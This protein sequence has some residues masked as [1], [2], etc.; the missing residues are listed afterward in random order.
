MTIKKILRTIGY[1]AFG[2]FVFIFLT[3][4][5][6]PYNKLKDSLF[7][8]IGRQSGVIIEAEDMKAT[9]GLAVKLSDVSLSHQRMNFPTLELESITLS[10]SLF[11]LVT[12]SPKI[13]FD[14]ALKKGGLNGYFQ[15]GGRQRVGLNLKKIQLQNEALKD[16]LNLDIS[17][18]LDGKI[19]VSGNLHDTQTLSGDARLDIKQFVLAKTKIMNMGLPEITISEITL[20][21]DL[22]QGTLLIKKFNAG[23]PAEDLEAQA[24]GDIRLDSRNVM[25]S[26]IT[27]NLKFKLSKKLQE[28]FSIFLPFIATALRPDG[29]YYLK[30]TGRLAAPLANPQ[31]S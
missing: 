3:Y 22:K 6:F 23:G 26:L 9:L 7:S 19:S 29:F 27:I 28:E 20:S 8:K 17:G 18:L 4:L 2:I 5:H 12:L 13:N 21:S 11:S 10:P 14:V 1:A 24:G 16:K 31:R 30:L 25:N 15:T